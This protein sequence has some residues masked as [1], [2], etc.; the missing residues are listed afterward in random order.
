MGKPF[1]E[2]MPE[3]AVA[4]PVAQAAFGFLLLDGFSLGLPFS[5]ISLEQQDDRARQEQ[6][7][8]SG[9]AVPM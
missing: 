8:C 5:L 1:A 4:E 3:C 7:A 2:P 6:T 9:I